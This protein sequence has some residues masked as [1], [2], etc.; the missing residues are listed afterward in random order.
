MPAMATG[1]GPDGRPAVFEGGA[2]L[3]HDRH[4]RWNGVD[5]VPVKS[6]QTAPWL[7]Q[8]GVGL[9]FLALIAYLVYTTVT[10]QSAFVLG[11]YVGV[12]VFFVVLIAIYRFVGR[13]GWI[14][15]VIRAGCGALAVL[16]ILTLIA[17]PPPT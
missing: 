10:T 2:W 13:W 6:A 3:S 16:K 15:M 11:Y 7:M 9:I 17:H 8:I 14:G 12:A 1:I 4:F 5:W